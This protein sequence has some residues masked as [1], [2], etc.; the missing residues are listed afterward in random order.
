M[1]SSANVA[2]LRGVLPLAGM[3][4]TDSLQSG[5]MIAPS[6]LTSW[7]PAASVS[8]DCGLRRIASSARSEKV[9]GR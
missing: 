2:Y 1:A 8:R 5:A 4:F 7:M 6:A 3:A 9:A